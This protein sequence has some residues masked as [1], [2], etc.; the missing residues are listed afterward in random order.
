MRNLA[1]KSALQS[2]DALSVLVE[3]TPLGNG[4]YLLRRFVDGKDYCDPSI[5]RWI[6]SIGKK[7]NNNQIIAATDMRFVGDMNFD[8]LFSR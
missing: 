3:G 8:C 7:F 1:M 2:G 4:M 5:E 6:F